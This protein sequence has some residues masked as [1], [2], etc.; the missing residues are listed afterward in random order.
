MIVKLLVNSSGTVDS[1]MVISNTTDNINFVKAAKRAAYKTVYL[2][3]KYKKENFARW[4][5]RKY[6][7]K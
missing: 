2:P 6:T 4:I 1:V 7:W 5:T 3:A